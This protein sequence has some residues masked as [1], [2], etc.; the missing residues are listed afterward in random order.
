M[1]QVANFLSLK[2][3]TQAGLKQLIKEYQIDEVEC[4]VADIHGVARGKVMPAYR[5]GEMQPTFL[6]FSIFFQTITGKYF[7]YES[8]D[9]STEI[10]IRLVP[11]LSTLRAL[12]WA[13]GSR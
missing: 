1:T 12:P 9:Y 5:F 4:V 11:D 8:D 10:D 7:D 3:P 13:P 2:S 6:P